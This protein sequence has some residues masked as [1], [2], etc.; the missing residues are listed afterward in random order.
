MYGDTKTRDMRIG[1]FISKDSEIRLSIAR[2]VVLIG[3]TLMFLLGMITVWTN[4]KTSQVEYAR[5]H[6]FKPVK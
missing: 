4:Y 5:V 6:A 1:G 3:F 2:N